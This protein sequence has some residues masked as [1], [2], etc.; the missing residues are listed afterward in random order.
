DSG[1]M[2][3]DARAIN[4]SGQIAADGIDANGQR[5]AVLLTPVGRVQVPQS[6]VAAALGGPAGLG[7][8]LTALPV[9]WVPP[10][11][12]GGPL[13][14]A[15]TAPGDEQPLPALAEPIGTRVPAAKAREGR[16]GL[17]AG[18]WIDGLWTELTNGSGNASSAEA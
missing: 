16:D 6:L 3:I 8:R 13:P 17:F 12:P 1:F 9:A 11:S 2:I 15:E 5:H 4:D 18:P 10:P 14:S 7:D